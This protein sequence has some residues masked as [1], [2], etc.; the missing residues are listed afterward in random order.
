MLSSLRVVTNWT[1]VHLV[2]RISDYALP[3]E[4][5]GTQASVP[6]KTEALDSERSCALTPMEV[7]FKGHSQMMNCEEWQG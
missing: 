6:P 3:F 4:A 7:P 5:G 1:L 2:G